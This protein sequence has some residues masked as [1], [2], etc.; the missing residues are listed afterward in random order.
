MTQRQFDQV[1]TY[2]FRNDSLTEISEEWLSKLFV[3]KQNFWL[4]IVAKSLRET[5]QVEI[6]WFFRLMGNQ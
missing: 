1:A 4:R 3:E 5:G 2:Q 6:M